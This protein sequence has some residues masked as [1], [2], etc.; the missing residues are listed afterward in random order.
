[1]QD[2]CSNYQDCLDFRPQSF[3]ECNN[4]ETFGGAF[5][6]KYIFQFYGLYFVIC[7]TYIH[8]KSENLIKGHN[9][10]LL[11][12]FCLNNIPVCLYVIH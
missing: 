11:F 1:M 8:I 6:V 12:S 2:P 10:D 7:I 3:H 9:M 5:Q 4:K